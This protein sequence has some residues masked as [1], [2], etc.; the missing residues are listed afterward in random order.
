MQPRAVL[1]EFVTKQ[2]P[3]R[4]RNVSSLAVRWQTTLAGRKSSL[5]SLR[6]SEEVRQVSSGNESE[7]FLCSETMRG[8]S[9]CFFEAIRSGPRERGVEKLGVCSG[10]D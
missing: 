1:G 9:E 10:R 8:P 6:R 3:N 4:K 7:R 2:E 5:F